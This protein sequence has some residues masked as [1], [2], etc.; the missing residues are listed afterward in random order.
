[1]ALCCT[2]SEI[3]PDLFVKHRQFFLSLFHLKLPIDRVTLFEFLE[4]LFGFKKSLIHGADS[5]DFAILAHR[6]FDSV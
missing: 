3:Y 5:E 1:M 4:E 6:C 2:V